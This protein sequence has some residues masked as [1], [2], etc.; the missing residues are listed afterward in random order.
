MLPEHARE[1]VFEV[2]QEVGEQIGN[3]YSVRKNPPCCLGILT[4]T[5]PAHYLHTR[6]LL[7]EPPG[8]GVRATVR[9]HVYQFAVFKV[10]QDRP[11]AGSSAESEVVDAQEDPRCFMILELQRA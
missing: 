3:K 11:I 8:E 1:H 7:L 6:V 5:I 9:Q 10:H 2:L 4:S